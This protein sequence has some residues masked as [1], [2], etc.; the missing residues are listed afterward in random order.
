MPAVATHVL[1]GQAVFL[2]LPQDI[3]DFLT[4]HRAYWTLGFQG[5]DLL[6]YHKPLTANAT[7]QLGCDLHDQSPHDF[8]QAAPWD[9]PRQ[10]AYL[11]GVCCHYGLDRVCHPVV[12]QACQQDSVGHR[13]LES[14]L[15]FYLL[16][17]NNLPLQRAGLISKLP[18]YAPIAMAFGLPVST[19]KRSGHAFCFYT[20]C[21]DR[22]K[23]VGLLKRPALSALC[24]PAQP[25]Y[26]Q[27]CADLE[28]QFH[29]AIPSTVA[30]VTRLYQWAEHGH[31]FPSDMAQNYEGVLPSM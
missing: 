22:P 29:Q 10:V 5:P 11:L 21:L 31:P 15:D 14:D 20:A 6:F 24:L 30:L 26:T 3:Q 8:F 18:D 4:P 7:A 17:K 13:L 9:D 28:A 19:V 23:L 27:T 25:M 16:S 1:F 2:Q 12:N